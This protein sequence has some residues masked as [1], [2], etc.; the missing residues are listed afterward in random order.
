MVAMGSILWEH[1]RTVYCIF[2]SLGAVTLRFI[3]RRVV[4]ITLVIPITNLV[5]LKSQV[6]M[7][8]KADSLQYTVLVLP[9]HPTTLF[10]FLEYT[11]THCLTCVCQVPYTV[12]N[13]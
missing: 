4:T 7:A 3:N 1:Y 2:L 12:P 9:L 6:H 5:R 13:A 10:R 11:L 8:M